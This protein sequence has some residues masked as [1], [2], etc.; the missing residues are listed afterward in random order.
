V[1][2]QKFKFGQWMGHEEFTIAVASLFAETPD[3]AYVL[4][5]ASTLTD[6]AVKTSEDDGFRQKVTVKAG[7]RHAE[8]ITL[9]PRVSLAPFRTFPELDQPVSDFVL[10][11]KGE[12]DGGK[13][14][15][16][17]VE[18]DGGRWKIEAIETIARK[19]QSYSLGIPI[20]A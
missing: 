5:L 18:A 16:M 4:T 20:I 10:R 9:K 11:A 3:K 17:L 12:G 7:M 19:L 15:L 8:G 2:F 14:L 13:P 6:E 1:S